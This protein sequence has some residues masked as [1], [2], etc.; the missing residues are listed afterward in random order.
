MHYPYLVITIDVSGT[1]GVEVVVVEA[2]L[3]A[4]GKGHLGLS[5]VAVSK[6]LVI[7][8]GYT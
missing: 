4:A 2:R 8:L 7:A 3:H 6:E 5:A 1:S